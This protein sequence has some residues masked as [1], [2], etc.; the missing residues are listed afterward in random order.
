MNNQEITL[1]KYS[2]GTVHRRGHG[3]K[4]VIGA[5]VSI[6]ENTIF[7]GGMSH[8]PKLITTF[9]FNC[10]WSGLSHLTGHPVLRGDIT[11]GNDCYIGQNS[12]IMSGV[13]VGDGGVVGAMSFVTKNIPPYEIWGGVPAKFIKK[14]FTDEQINKLLELKW[15]DFEDSEIEKIAPMLMS[16]NI[17]ELFEY[18]KLNY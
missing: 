2:Y 15:W 14:R 5:F 1:G 12:I 11:I 9:P 16:E 3:N 13:T 6:G 17:E 10:V 8:N 18:Y 7:D 4:V